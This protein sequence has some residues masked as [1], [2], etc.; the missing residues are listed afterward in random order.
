MA[1]RLIRSAPMQTHAYRILAQRR[2]WTDHNGERILSALGAV[3]EMPGLYA[4]R[5]EARRA[6]M[7][8][9]NA[10]DWEH[11]NPHAAHYFYWARRIDVAPLAPPAAGPEAGA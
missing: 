2:I 6:I 4:S 7:T 3:E 10:P 8:M 11:R 5:S 9:V 1:K